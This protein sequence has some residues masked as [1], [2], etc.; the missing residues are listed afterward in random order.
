ML[1]VSVRGN[2]RVEVCEYGKDQHQPQPTANNKQQHCNINRF[3]II[4]KLLC[5]QSTVH[6]VIL[7]VTNVSKQQQ[8]VT[9]STQ[10][11]WSDHLVYDVLPLNKKILPF[12]HYY[13]AKS[14]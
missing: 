11:M 4:T 9:A 14:Q 1:R 10:F 2:V 6:I 3:G 12:H 5:M 13:N 7:R 8:A